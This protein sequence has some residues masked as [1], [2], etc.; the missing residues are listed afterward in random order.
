MGEGVL[1]LEGNRGAGRMRKTHLLG[2]AGVQLGGR[3]DGLGGH[4][5]AG[6][7]ARP[8]G[9]EGAGA[10]LVGEDLH[11]DCLFVWVPG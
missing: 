1:D 6:R 11:G 10:L 8:L 7:P 2:A 3:G 5:G 9:R 4:R